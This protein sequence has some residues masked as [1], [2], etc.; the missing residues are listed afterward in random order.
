MPAISRLNATDVAD[1]IKA[2]KAALAHGED[3]DVAQFLPPLDHPSY[4]EIHNKLLALD[5]EYR[6]A[7]N[8]VAENQVERTIWNNGRVGTPKTG[9]QEESELPPLAQKE[10]TTARVVV[11]VQR[12]DDVGAGSRS[13]PRAVGQ[14]GSSRAKPRS[15]GDTAERLAGVMAGMP[16]AGADFLNFRILAELGRGAFGRVYLA[17]QRD[18]ASRYV[19]LKLSPDI[20]GESQT[21]A[22]L[23]HTNIVPI[24]SVHR[25][26]PYQAVCMPYFGATTL[27]DLLKHWRERESLPESGKELVSTLCGR[28]STTRQLQETSVSQQQMGDA[29]P[30]LLAE[31]P[32]ACA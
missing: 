31:S 22:Q 4:T 18:L 12:P 29:C 30:Q 6:A 7:G 2:Y 23:Q 8:A 32:P 27:A 3:V 16:V 13:S 20:L 26:S 5:L 10:V 11:H 14:S 25:A 15:N 19:A 1:F 28:K 21:L 17:Q 24:Y 9:P